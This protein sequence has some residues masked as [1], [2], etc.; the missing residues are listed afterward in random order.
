MHGLPFEPILTGMFLL[1][2]FDDC[3][4]DWYQVET[5]YSLDLHLIFD[6]M[7]NFLH[8]GIDHLYF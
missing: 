6:K 3:Y 7:L 1:F 5:Q 8:V 4:S 2:I